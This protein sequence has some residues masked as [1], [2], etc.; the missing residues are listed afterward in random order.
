MTSE[1]S[2][3]DPVLK[4]YPSCPVMFTKNSDVQGGLANGS[5]LELQTIMLKAGVEKM[6]FTFHGYSV[7]AVYAHDIAYAVV[8]F[9]GTN[10]RPRKIQSQDYTFRCEYPLPNEFQNGGNMKRE[11]LNMKAN[12][13]PFVSNTATTG[14]K[15]Q[16]ATKDSLYVPFWHY[17]T[18][19]WP[20]VVLSRVRTRK[21]LFIGEKLNPDKDYS[22][23]HR[24]VRMIIA[25][26]R[27]TPVIVDIDDDEA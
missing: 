26:R 4:T 13:F 5:L 11:W 25:F 19:N 6:S 12:Q 21:G 16:G 24:I 14:H 22:L 23:D 20:Y 8:K 7:P 27:L 2:R 1:R 15:L 17:S 9:P 3:I 18:P 10:L